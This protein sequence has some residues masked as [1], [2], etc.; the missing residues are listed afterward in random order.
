MT[1]KQPLSNFK[2]APV[3]LF[4]AVAALALLLALAGTLGPAGAVHAAGPF[5]VN[6][7]AD[8]HDGALGNGTCQ[9]AGGFCSLRAAIE[10]AT[11]LGGANT[12][13][14]PPGTYNLSLGELKT[15]SAAGTNI[16]LAG[17]GTPANTIISQT[18]GVSRVFNIDYS[19]HG[20]VIVGIRHV[21]IQNGVG[22]PGGGGGAILDGDVGDVLNLNDVTFTNN[23]TSSFN[24]GAI[25]FTGGGALN[26]LNSTFVNNSS[27]TG[28]GGAIHFLQTQ[29]GSLSVSG[30]TFT[31]N[32][33]SG[34]TLGG[35]G[36]AINVGC[37]ICSPFSI[38]SSTFTANTAFRVGSSGGQGGA[39]MFGAGTLTLNFNRITGNTAA[40]GGSGIFNGGGA[41]GADNNWW[42]CNGG[43]GSAGCDTAVNGSGTL[44]TIPRIV[45]SLVANPNAI[46]RGLSSSLTAS[47]LQNSSGGTLTPTQISVL[48]G[49]PVTWSTNP[50]FGSLSGQQAAIQLSGTATATFTSNGVPG[51]SSST[52]R[53]DNQ[54]VT[55]TVPVLWLVELPIIRH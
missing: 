25:S 21:T 40:G 36:G 7:T 47:F 37:N 15:G 1:P 2:S 34:G 9:D 24:G 8:T 50:A 11:A 6:T 28:N 44:T 14:L 45:L 42:G 19:F 17:S 20:S 39:I 55:A 27:P 30:S 29:A 5:T 10:E 53:V 31:G 33:A 23:H 38:T 12:I 49:L 48:L 52:A 43:P 16:T 22:G 46:R 35:Q 54:T 51:A 41:A 3:R 18:D 26:V 4:A 13:N 32:S